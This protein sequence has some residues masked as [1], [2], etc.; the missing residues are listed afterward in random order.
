MSEEYKLWKDELPE[1]GKDIIL[2]DDEGESHQVFRC[3]C[4]NPNCKA[5]RMV[6]GG[7][8]MVD[9]VKWKYDPN[10]VKINEDF[11]WDAAM[12]EA[13]YGDNDTTKEYLEFYERFKKAI[14]KAFGIPRKYLS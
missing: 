4:G 3:N 8:L 12:R 6:L 5:V 14:A 1:K 9:P 7:E 10:P 11:D 13:I 2:I